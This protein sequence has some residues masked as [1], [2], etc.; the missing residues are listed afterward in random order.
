MAGRCT[1]CER[2]KR[3]YEA[4]DAEGRKSYCEECI[5]ELMKKAVGR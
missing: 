3:V 2:L 5:R 1:A 4:G